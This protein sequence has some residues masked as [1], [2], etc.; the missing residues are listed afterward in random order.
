MPCPV[1]GCTEF[2]L[3]DP[4]DEF[5]T[6]EFELE[7]AGPAF[8]SPPESDAALELADD[9]ETFCNRCSWHGKFKE[10]ID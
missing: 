9:T 10:L 5:E 7:G 4:E 2:Y 8:R 6:Y 3:K 1:C